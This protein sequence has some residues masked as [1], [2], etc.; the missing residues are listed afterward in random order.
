MESNKN[1]QDIKGTCHNITGVST[2][3]HMFFHSQKN[4][5]D[6]SKA[7]W[8]CQS[9]QLP[10]NKKNA[11]NSYLPIVVSSQQTNSRCVRVNLDNTNGS[12]ILR[13]ETAELVPY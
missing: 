4:E 5:E 11:G 9:T 6:I 3:F 13:R 1:L 10:T 7:K 2:K 12:K 8:S